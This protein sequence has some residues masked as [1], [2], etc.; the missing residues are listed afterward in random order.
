MKP[1][2]RDHPSSDTI[3]QDSVIPYVKGIS[4]A[5]GTVSI[6]GPFSKLNIHSMEQ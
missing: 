5:L 6:S 1:L 2:T 3:F 4:D